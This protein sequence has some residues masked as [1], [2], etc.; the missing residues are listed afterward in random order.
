MEGGL[1][2]IV[3]I[4]IESIE[5]RYSADWNRWF[6]KRTNHD[7]NWKTISPSLLT[8]K[9]DDGSFLDITGTSY[10]KAMQLA[11]IAQSIKLGGIPRDKRV[12]FF[13]QDGWFP[14]E[15]I[16][17]MRDMLGCHDWRIV[18][19]FHAGTFD[20]WDMTSNQKM[21]LWGEDLENAWF[22]IYD[23][24]IVNSEF[25]RNLLLETRKIQSSK[26]HVIPYHVEVPYFGNI[27]K[28]NIVVFPH[29]LDKEK[30]PELFAK[31]AERFKDSGW[32][33]IA[34]KGV[35]NLTKQKYYEI[36]AKSKISISCAL[37]ETFGIAMVE[38]VLLG[39]MP[40]VPDRLAYKEMYPSHYRYNDFDDL[41]FKLKEYMRDGYQFGHVITS[42]FRYKY[43]Q[44]DFFINI[45]NLLETV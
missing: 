35:A 19:Y 2:M 24:V 3:N 38:S 11:A 30:Q 27:V 5:D 18:G 45:F 12:V 20:P 29:R 14:V 9:I 22:K 43:S 28:E 17:Y 40:L 42:D 39:C 4:P 21:Y 15:Q 23:A 16:A 33:F 6:H 13:I 7:E 36:L 44:E 32:E 8:N 31:L 10:F 34:T 41:C 1:L 25:E 37:Q 26:I